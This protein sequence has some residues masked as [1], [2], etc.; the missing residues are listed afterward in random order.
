VILLAAGAWFCAGIAAALI[1]G[2][3]LAILQSTVPPELQGRVFTLQ[4]SVVTAMSPLGLALSG[5]FVH[6]WGAS[7]WFFLTGIVH[8]AAGV[9][10]WFLPSLMRIEDNKIVLRE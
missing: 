4:L 3:S 10:A 6:V 8:A 7:L 5:P 2:R 9:G 1:N